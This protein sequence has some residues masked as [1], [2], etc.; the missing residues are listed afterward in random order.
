[1]ANSNSEPLT[2]LCSFDDNYA[3]PFAAMVTSARQYTP[4]H[5]Q[6]TV[7]L[8]EAFLTAE[9]RARIDQFA[10]RLP[11]TRLRWLQLDTQRI[12]NA[13]LNMHFTLASYARLL[14][15]EEIADCNRLI[16]LDVDLIC[17]ADLQEL[18][19]EPLE[20]KVLGAVLDPGATYCFDGHTE[21]LGLQ[22][23]AVHFN[24]G[25]LL[26]DLVEWKRQDL[27]NTCLRFIDQRRDAIRWVDQD[28]LNGVVTNWHKLP[29]HWNAQ[30]QYFKLEWMS[31]LQQH[32]PADLIA[33]QTPK[34]VHFNDPIKPWHSEYQH[35]LRHYFHHFDS[36]S[37][38]LRNP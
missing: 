6:L 14:A 10:G 8:V 21:A 28:V 31:E 19:A 37:G 4:A 13:P 16:Y 11:N 15:F 33:A 20:A 32:F 12:A 2:I 35:P 1:M 18:L 5:C 22:S 25:A 36:Q 27:T 9:M 26:V 23:G 30:S 38:W 24:A 3:R 7:I 34:I 17:L 29:S